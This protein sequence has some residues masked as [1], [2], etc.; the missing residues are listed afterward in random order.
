MHF[1]IN[2]VICYKPIPHVHHH[3]C[4]CSCCMTS[5]HPI[6]YHFKNIPLTA[7]RGFLSVENDILAAQTLQKSIGLPMFT[8]SYF[9]ETDAC[10]DVGLIF[11]KSVVLKLIMY[12]Y[13]HFICRYIVFKA[14]F[15]REL[16][17]LSSPKQFEM[18]VDHLRYIS[19]Q[20]V[21]SRE[22]NYIAGLKS[23]RHQ[24]CLTFDKL[25][26]V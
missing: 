6:F 21:K 2:N 8:F 5:E 1:L 19:S 24:T 7:G 12:L 26:E 13:I 16:M 20:D 15:W 23:D 3:A 17:D 11:F 9:A 10:L 22:N 18:P 14:S 4:M 25:K